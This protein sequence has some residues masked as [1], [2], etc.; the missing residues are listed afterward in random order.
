MA[1][2]S[3]KLPDEL[4]KRVS[5]AAKAAGQSPHAFMLAAI[6]QQ[7]RLAEARRAFMQQALDARK[8][9]EESGVG[10]EASEVHA[11]LAR[12]AESKRVRRPKPKPWRG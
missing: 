4:K 2:T 1:A 7:T 5:A 6:E 9:M 8:S 10:Y 3:I 12:R 11:Y